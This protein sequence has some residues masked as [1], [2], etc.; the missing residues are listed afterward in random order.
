[1][2]NNSETFIFKYES[3]AYMSFKFFKEYEAVPDI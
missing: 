2:T 1:V 3:E